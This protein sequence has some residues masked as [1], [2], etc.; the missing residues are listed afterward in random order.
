MFPKQLGCGLEQSVLSSH[1]WIIG[2]SSSNHLFVLIIARQF[3]CS[4]ACSV[5]C[6]A[7][8]SVQ[9]AVQPAV[10]HAAWH[11]FLVSSTLCMHVQSN[12]LLMDSKLALEILNG[13]CPGF[14]ISMHIWNLECDLEINLLVSKSIVQIR[15]S[16]CGLEIKLGIKIKH[17]V[18]FGFG[19]PHIRECSNGIKQRPSG[20]MSHSLMHQWDLPEPSEAD[21]D[22]HRMEKN[23]RRCRSAFS[24]TVTVNVQKDQRVVGGSLFGSSCPAFFCS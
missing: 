10:Q 22:K 4:A 1:H 13:L 11:L 7:A 17:L 20:G 24:L 15:S 12:S 18:H 2:K 8:C 9:L 23:H 3:D 19:F 16:E 14:E 5:A 21:E 6:S